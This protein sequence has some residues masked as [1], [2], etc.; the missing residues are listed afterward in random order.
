MKLFVLVSIFLAPSVK[1]TLPPKV[2]YQHSQAR[3]FK[4]AFFKSIF[5]NLPSI[6]GLIMGLTGLSLWLYFIYHSTFVRPQLS[7]PPPSTLN[8][9]PQN[10]EGDDVWVVMTFKGTDRFRRIFLVLAFKLLGEKIAWAAHWALLV[11][12]KDRSSYFEL[13]RQ[14]DCDVPVRCCWSVLP[15]GAGDFEYGDISMEP[16]DS[17]LPYTPDLLLSKIPELHR[18]Y[19]GKTSLSDREI[20]QAGMLTQLL[21]HVNH[22]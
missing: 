7:Q 17:P 13:E 21:I 6:I 22:I 5:A 10:P 18:M 16:L 9:L 3:T 2:L 8:P 12:R 1:L 4:M 14:R 11:E 20:H 15:E 19:V